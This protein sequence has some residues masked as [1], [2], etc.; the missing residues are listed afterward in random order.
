MLFDTIVA[1]PPWNQKAGRKLSGEYVIKGGKQVFKA[2]S[3][4]TEDLPYPTMTIEN[5]CNLNIPSAD[6]AHLYLW[7]T[8]KYLKEAFE[9]MEA[10]GF[11]YSTTLVWCK[12]RMGGGLGGAH[13][14]TTEFCLFGRKGN[15]PAI[16]V[17]ETTWYNW[18]RP[19]FNGKPKH[20][21]KPDEFYEL[22]K[23]VSPVNHL[24]MFSRR[25]RAGWYHWGNEFP[26]DI[27][28]K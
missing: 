11:T 21:A 23:R 7:A 16:G 17:G 3:N 12:N 22:V 9:V 8:N 2:K 14:I 26:N 18:K 25:K 6:N 4:K 28:L 19:Y 10:W 15:L 5:I 1:D 27:E 24:E 13:R 20:S